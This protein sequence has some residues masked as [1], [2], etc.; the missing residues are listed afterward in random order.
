MKFALLPGFN[1]SDGGAATVGQLKPLLEAAGHEV[2]VI[3]YGHYNLWE[4]HFKKHKAIRQIAL[5]LKKEQVDV[6][7]GH[8][9]GCNFSHLSLRLLER[10]SHKYQEVRIA[11]ALNRG[12]AC[13]KNVTQC[14]V[15]YSKSDRWTFLSGFIP[16]SPWGQQGTYGY[17]G[18]DPKMLGRNMGDL[19]PDHSDYFDEGTKQLVTDEILL[20]LE[21]H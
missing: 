11:P 5:R 20:S 21:R 2:I 3:D 6:V 18:N 4:V 7:L 1:V 8:S 14:L 10:Y 16:G 15:L 19:V 9:N 17:R 12:T 13:A